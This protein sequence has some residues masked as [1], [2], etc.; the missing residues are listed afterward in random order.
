MDPWQITEAIFKDTEQYLVP[1]WNAI[2]DKPP[3]ELE[4]QSVQVGHWSKVNIQWLSNNRVPNM[5]QFLKTSLPD[6]FPRLL[7]HLPYVSP[8]SDILSKLVNSDDPHPQLRIIDWLHEERLVQLAIDMLDPATSPIEAHTP[9]GE[10][11]RGIVAAASAASASKQQQQQQ[12]HAA[13]FGE[14]SAESLGLNGNNSS[15]AAWTNWPN[16]AL[17]RELASRETVDRLL[18]YMLD[19]RPIGP[20]SSIATSG[21]GEVD[22]SSDEFAKSVANGLDSSVSETDRTPSPEA[23]KS[24]YFEANAAPD[25]SRD[26]SATNTISSEAATSSLLNSLTLIIDIIRKN[27]SDFTELQILQYLERITGGL[28]DN[29]S[30]EEH[31]GEGEGEESRPSN[32]LLD[33]GPS[34]VDLAPLLTGIT[35]RLPELHKIL[36]YPRAKVS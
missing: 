4:Q 2:L 8:I 11:L 21:E 12:Q 25:A 9:A 3:S 28:D 29:D 1:F 14:I 20:S 6:L 35:K 36:L 34:L 24:S 32:Q 17:V 30:D 7:V 22:A 10:F 31:G 33:Q 19:S 13:K 15:S 27:N 23:V 5:I 26:A 16:N 18:G